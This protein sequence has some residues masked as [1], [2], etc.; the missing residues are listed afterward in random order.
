V[1]GYSGR[2]ENV[3]DMFKKAIDQNNAFPHGLFWTTPKL[4]DAMECVR[5]LITYEELAKPIKA[6]GISSQRGQK[7]K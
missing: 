5:E 4:S 7:R 6:S 3:M 1:S 2:D